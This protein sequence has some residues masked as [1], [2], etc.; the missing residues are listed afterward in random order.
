[1]DWLHYLLLT[2]VLVWMVAFIWMAD[3]FRRTIRDMKVAYVRAL[4]QLD[5]IATTVDDFAREDHRTMDS[6]FAEI[7]PQWR[8]RL[9]GFEVERNGRL[10]QQSA[11]LLN[12]LA[13]YRMWADELNDYVK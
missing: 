13:N 12:K 10:Q 1:M 5:D 6:L 4:A 8:A 11:L 3:R 7:P 9:R 2:A